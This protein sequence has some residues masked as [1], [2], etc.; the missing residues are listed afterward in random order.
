MRTIRLLTVG[1]TPLDAMQRYGPI[2]SRVTRVIS[3]SGPTILI[4]ATVCTN[5]GVYTNLRAC[6]YIHIHTYIHMYVWSWII[7]SVATRASFIAQ[8]SASIAIWPIACVNTA[9]LI[10]L[11]EYH[12]SRTQ[13]LHVHK[14]TVTKS[15]VVT[16]YQ[17]EFRHFFFAISTKLSWYDLFYLENYTWTYFFVLLYMHTRMYVVT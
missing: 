7:W 8:R 2:W 1:G 17:I 14:Y 15:I 4:A 5:S 11:T 6:V 9:S 3:S 10:R 12:G 16:K 13:F